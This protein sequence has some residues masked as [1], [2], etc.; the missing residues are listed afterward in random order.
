[1][2]TVLHVLPH[3]GGGAETYIDLLEG[4]EGYEHRRIAL[5]VSR[6]RLRGVPSVLGRLRELRRLSRSADLVHL[7]GDMAAMLAAP[8][9]A[10]V[11]PR[12]G[13]G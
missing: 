4:L 8:A 9:L 7:H 13:G 11:S 2:P 3:P 10:G 1:M 6:S 12:W 5:S